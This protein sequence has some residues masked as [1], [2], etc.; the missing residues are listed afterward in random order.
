MPVTYTSR[1]GHTY[2][3]YKGQTKTGKPRYYF[4]RTGQGEGEPV[5]EIPPGYTISE[6]VNGIVSLAKDR[7]SSILPEEK[8]AVEEALKQHPQ[9]RQYRI[10]IKHNLIEIYEQITPNY[11]TVVRELHIPGLFLKPGLSEELQSY[12]EQH[13][14]YAPVLQFTLLD[15]KQRQ[16]GAKRMCYRSSVDGWLELRGKAGTVAELA[17]ELIPTL[18]TDKFFDLW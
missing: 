18:G 15:P 4:S 11:E 16:F 6:S 10:A 13:N 7:P 12:Q 17:N 2:T 8:A 5:T 1:K 9:A 3:L 14:Q